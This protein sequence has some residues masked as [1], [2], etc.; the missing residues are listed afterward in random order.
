MRAMRIIAVILLLGSTAEAKTL[1]E[2]LDPTRDTA[3]DWHLG[4]EGH[5]DFPLSVGFQVWAELPRYRIRISTSFGEMP[6][7]YLDLINTVAVAVGAYDNNMA[8][9]IS[10]ALDKAF[11]WRLHVGWRPWKH[12]GAYFEVG[13][14]LLEVHK[15]IGLVPIL[16]KATGIT[17]PPELNLGY[18]YRINTLVNTV[19]VE[20]GWMWWPWRDLTVRFALGFAATVEANVDIQ[21]NFLSSKQAV[22]T[23]L[24]A[25]H[26]EQLIEE[27]LFIPTI[28][29]GLGWQLF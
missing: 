22:F 11:S 4:I 28:G 29:L 18:G 7:A 19:G 20:V 24:A 25:F 6:D 12:R 5:T 26:L 21:P 27:H 17:A 1:H 9:F 23:R 15:S 13:Y 8:E 16:E 14:G 2:E 3:R 10:E